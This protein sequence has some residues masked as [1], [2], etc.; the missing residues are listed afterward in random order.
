MKIPYDIYFQ[1]NT[2]SVVLTA[3]PR[4]SDRYNV[5]ISHTGQMVNHT[6]LYKLNSQ[7]NIQQ[8][9]VH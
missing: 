1:E 2:L 7:S 5:D 4:M 6:I 3:P 8:I 9:I